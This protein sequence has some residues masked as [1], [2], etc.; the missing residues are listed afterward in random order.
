MGGTS[1]S[2]RLYIFLWK[3]ECQSPIRNRIF[4]YNR[5]IS[6]FIRAEFVSDRMLYI[7]VKGRCGDIIL[8]NMHA[9]NDDK[10]YIKDRFTK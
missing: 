8:L 7:T 4:V 6:A 10:D 1:N 3:R 9:P 5:S 2:R